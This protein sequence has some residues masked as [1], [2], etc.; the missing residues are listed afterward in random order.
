MALEK[1]TLEGVGW[2]H[3]M[4]HWKAGGL[5]VTTQSILI[6][7]MN[8]N[9]RNASAKQ[10]FLNPGFVLLQH[11]IIQQET[12]QVSG[13]S[14][15][16]PWSPLLAPLFS[17]GECGDNLG[18]FRNHIFAIIYNS[19]EAK[20]HNPSQ[21]QNKKQHQSDPN[22]ATPL[23]TSTVWAKVQICTQSHWILWNRTLH[24]SKED[25]P[26]FRGQNNW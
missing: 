7:L 26:L 13:M 10:C 9:R 17:P 15:F 8:V 2:S 11:Q 25:K 1:A 6:P 14:L 24:S 22:P 19:D 16:L 18:S 3:D 21:M 5:K 23:M 20:I 4:N 12:M